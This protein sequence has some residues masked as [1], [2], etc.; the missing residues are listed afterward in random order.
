MCR[1]YSCATSCARSPKPTFTSPPSVCWAHCSTRLCYVER[2]HPFGAA[3]LADEDVAV[4]F[5]G[6]TTP[7]DRVAVV[8]TE[9]LT[10]D[11]T[12]TPL[13]P[14]ELA[15]F[16]AGRRVALPPTSRLPSRARPA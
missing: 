5:A 4:D 2:A 14:G 6:L 1:V 11:E 13:A 9:P 8:V 3:R 7:D 10:L 16:E 12:W 15:V